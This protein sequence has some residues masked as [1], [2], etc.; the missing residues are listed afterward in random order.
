[1]SRAAYGI[2]K[3]RTKRV[4]RDGLNDRGNKAMFKEGSP[5]GGIARQ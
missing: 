5:E 3:Q 4:R 1:M 2:M